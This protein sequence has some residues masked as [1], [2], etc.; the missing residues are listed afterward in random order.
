[1]IPRPEE[2]M[3]LLGF[4]HLQIKVRDVD[5][6]LRFY[7]DAL[8]MEYRFPPGD[9]LV[10]LRTPGGHD[11]FT[12]N[13]S[14]EGGAGDLGGV[15]HFGFVFQEAADVE[16]AWAAVAEAGGKQLRHWEPGDERVFAFVEDP[17][18]YT[19]ELYAD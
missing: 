1:M 10:F 5:R 19:V 4:A 15:Q 9:G 16:R 13:P 6:S 7:R 11:T 8:G 3:G 12:L 17:D 18:G 14:A 2:P